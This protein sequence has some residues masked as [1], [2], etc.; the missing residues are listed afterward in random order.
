MIAAASSDGRSCS[1]LD[2]LFG[3]AVG[4]QRGARFGTELAQRLHRQPAVALD[5]Q[6]ERGLP[7]LL[8]ELGE[9]LREVGRVLL[10]EQVDQVR[11][12]PHAHEALHGVEHD[13]ELALGHRSIRAMSGNH[14]I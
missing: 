2:D 11:R 10:L 12:R 7:I 6:R 4:E 13:I 3:G 8:G 1:E 5:E 9:E 14:S